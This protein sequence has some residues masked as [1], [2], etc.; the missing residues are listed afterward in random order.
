MIALNAK[1]SPSTDSP[2]PHCSPFL[3]WQFSRHESKE[4]KAVVFLSLVATVKLQPAL[5]VSLE[6][7]A[8]KFLDSINPSEESA[9][10]F[11]HSFGGTIAVSSTVFI[12]CIV[13]LISSTSQIIATTAM[14]I[15]RKLISF[16]SAKYRLTLIRTDL[17]QQLIN[18][19]NPQSLSFVEAVDILVHLLEILR[20]FLFLI[21]PRALTKLESEGRNEKQ[22]VFEAVLQQ[23]LVPSEK[24][25]RHLCV[26]RF[27]IIDGYQ[28]YYLLSLL[29][30]LLEISPYSQP[31]RDFVLRMPIVLTIP[32]CITFFENEYT[33]WHFLDEMNDAQQEW[34]ERGGKARQMGKKVLRM[35]RMEGIEDV[36]E[37]KLQTNR[38]GT[39]GG[40]IVDESIRWNNLQG[41]NLS[42]QE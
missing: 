27:S 28:S 17:I 30:R 14:K 6:G 41:M 4:V 26:N 18:A 20:Y 8:V 11:L 3:N 34:N 15:L 12:Q 13:I 16:C 24:Y 40:G 36:I 21:T 7:K 25:I 29:A 42:K 9:D 23:V 37:D 32:S 38:N 35:L 10:A 5:D 2:D 31:T 39:N 1:T 19:L 22:A 33:I